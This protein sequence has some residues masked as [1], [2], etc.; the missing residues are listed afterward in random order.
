M[1]LF[2]VMQFHCC[3]HGSHSWIHFVTNSVQYVL[4]TF[5]INSRLF[6]VS[7]MTAVTRSNHMSHSFSFIRKQRWVNIIITA[8]SYCW[9]TFS[10]DFTLSSS[11]FLIIYKYHN[12]HQYPCTSHS[13][14]NHCLRRSSR[15]D[16]I[17]KRCTFCLAASLFSKRHHIETL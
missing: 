4:C 2:G 3:K 12:S 8:S 11:S 13:S 6:S 10:I 9:V 14:V 16:S 1:D 5:N 7:S 15:C 17:F